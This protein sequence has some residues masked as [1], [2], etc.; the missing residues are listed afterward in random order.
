MVL[1]TWMLAV[2]AAFVAVRMTTQ[3]VERWSH[4]QVQM[5]LGGGAIRKVTQPHPSTALIAGTIA[6]D[7]AFLL[8]L[9]L[10]LSVTIRVRRGDT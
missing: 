2:F 5:F 4:P 10:A 6:I 7:V 9:W 8:V 1:S 3:L